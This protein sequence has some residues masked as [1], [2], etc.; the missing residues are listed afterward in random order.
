MNLKLMAFNSVQYLAEESKSKIDSTIYAEGNN[1]IND[2]IIDV[3]K[4]VGGIGGS[5][6]TLAILII[7]LVI[8]FGSISAAKMRT[9]WM[10]LIS[11]S[12]GALIFYAAWY[13]APAIA[14]ITK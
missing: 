13:L 11:C 4:L 8:I 12:A 3:I 1:K 5:A 10:A 9:V 14:N 7:T 2:A 6:F